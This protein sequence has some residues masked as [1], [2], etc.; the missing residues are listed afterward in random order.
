MA[1]RTQHRVLVNCDDQTPIELPVDRM[2][3]RAFRA[4]DEVPNLVF[5]CTLCDLPHARIIPGDKALTLIDLGAQHDL[6]QAPDAIP[7][8][9]D[10]SSN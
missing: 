10:T 6:P 8:W 2:F 3:V 4:H 7:D 5:V 1:Q 9:L